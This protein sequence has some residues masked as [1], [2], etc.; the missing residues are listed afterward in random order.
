M[1][2]KRMG[3]LISFAERLLWRDILIFGR[4]RKSI[5]LSG[6]KNNG[7]VGC[8]EKVFKTHCE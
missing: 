1:S 5:I 4:M 3:L 2:V 7:E 6:L 8:F